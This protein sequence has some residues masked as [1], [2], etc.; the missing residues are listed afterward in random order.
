MLFIT[1]KKSCL[2]RP[3]VSNETSQECV[4]YDYVHDL[5]LHIK[6][7][8][9]SLEALTSF[10]THGQV[11]ALWQPRL[12]TCR[13]NEEMSL[14]DFLVNNSD[15]IKISDF[16]SVTSFETF[17]RWRLF[18]RLQDAWWQFFSSRMK[19][20]KGFYR[21]FVNSEKFVESCVVC[22]IIIIFWHYDH[23]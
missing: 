5:Y 1:E 11:L 13:K 6:R 21:E 4:Y 14:D 22:T 2:L 3:T 16:T 7:T 17:S 20:A 10:T 18:R 19:A 9:N 23:L 12:K 15:P 8:L